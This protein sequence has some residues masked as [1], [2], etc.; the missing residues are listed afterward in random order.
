MKNEKKNFFFIF[1]LT[2]KEEEEKQMTKQIWYNYS[3]LAGSIVN[4]LT[5]IIMCLNY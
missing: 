1:K 3:I 2:G 4:Y 5:P